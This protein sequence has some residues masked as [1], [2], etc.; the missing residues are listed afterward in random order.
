MFLSMNRIVTV[1]EATA[2]VQ[3]TVDKIVVL[4]L[5][6]IWVQNLPVIRVA[7]CMSLRTL[8]NSLRKHLK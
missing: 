3:P 7:Q 1:S 6:K 2:L 5:R 4:G 8:L